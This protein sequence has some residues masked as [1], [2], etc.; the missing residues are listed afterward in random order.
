MIPQEELQALYESLAYPSALKLRRA[1][2][3]RERARAARQRPADYEPWSLSL[4][5]AKAFVRKQGQRQILAK[6]QPY[7]GKII[8]S[9]VDERWAADLIQYTSQP[10]EI[11]GKR[12][13]FVLI[14]QDIFTRYIW[15]RALESTKYVEVRDAFKDIVQ[16]SGRKP[17]ELNTDQGPEFKKNPQLKVYLETQSIEH[18]LKVGV[19]DIATVD[20]AIGTLRKA[21]TRRTATPGAGNWAQELAAATRAYN[22]SP[23][24]HLDG[25]AP[26]DATGDDEA[27][28]SLRFDLKGKAADDAVTQD[29]VTRRKRELLEEVGAFREPV[30]STL[31]GLPPRGYKPRYKTGPPIR[32]VSVDATTNE[33]VGE[34]GKR[35]R[36]KDVMAVPPDSTA[37]RDPPGQ[38]VAGD[39]RV[40]RRQRE[41]TEDL[42]RR[43]VNILAT[44]RTL[45]ELRARIGP[46]DMATLQAQKLLPIRKFLE[47]WSDTFELRNGKWATREGA[48]S[49]SARQSTL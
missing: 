35:A 21:L 47:L 24:G 6:P 19:N 34:G 28:K 46:E 31:R 37:T 36:I 7:D 45:V 26:A 22:E 2:Q 30:D 25:E 9:M 4:K 1:V 5:D 13:Q 16:K 49:S 38:G 33:V 15:T 20:A 40:I 23:H 12:Y 17:K 39:A 43:V 27:A 8:A 14:V 11:G 48:A 18:R 44:P 41:A 3:L 42:K 10:A 32:V 29:R